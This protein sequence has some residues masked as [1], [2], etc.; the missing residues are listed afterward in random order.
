MDSKKTYA[1]TDKDQ[2]VLSLFAQVVAAIVTDMGEVEASSREQ[3]LYR[4]LQQVYDLRETHPKWTEFLNCYL[5]LVA[6]GGMCELSFL[7]VSDEWGDNYLLEGANK[8]FPPD[9]VSPGQLFSMN[10]GLLFSAGK[11]AGMSPRG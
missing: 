8:P 9:I 2:R 7:V 11:T 4:F 10:S 5:A 3:M 1:F 6:G